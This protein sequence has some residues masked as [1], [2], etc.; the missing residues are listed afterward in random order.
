MEFKRI[1]DATCGTKV[2]FRYGGSPLQRGR[3]GLLVSSKAASRDAVCARLS[4]EHRRQGEGVCWPGLQALLVEALLVSGQ[5]K[6]LVLHATT[7]TTA[8]SSDKVWHF[9]MGEVGLTRASSRPPALSAAPAPWVP[10]A[11]ASLA[12]R[13]RRR[14]W[15]WP[16]RGRPRF[17]RRPTAGPRA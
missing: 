12:S 2:H 1:D 4:C 5:Q 3:A 11:S 13:R 6:G 10:P 17:A 8:V 14:P 9:Q 16:R 15:A 7:A